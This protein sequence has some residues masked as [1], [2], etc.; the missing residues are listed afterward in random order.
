MPN[1]GADA[2]DR[3]VLDTSAYARMRN[4][5]PHVMSMAAAAQVVIMP[6]TVLGEL[7]GGFGLGSR[8]NE[9]R[10]LLNEFL[11]EPFVAVLDTT[12]SVARRYGEVFAMLR[13]AGTPI[14]TNDIW[15][16]AATLDC[17][18]RLLTFDHHFEKVAGL[19]RVRPVT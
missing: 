4:A 9:N 14:P 15:I 1:F 12:P 10:M 5:D 16:A 13:M 3:L 11:T 7:E 19:P 8:A 2:I 6:A 17:G 18:G